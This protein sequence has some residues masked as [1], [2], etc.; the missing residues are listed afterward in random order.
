M[1]E[2]TEQ[3]ITKLFFTNPTEILYL[4]HTLSNSYISKL[5]TSLNQKTLNLFLNL[6]KLL[7]VTK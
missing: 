5:K 4:Q 1:D 2:R 7:V 6:L 3:L